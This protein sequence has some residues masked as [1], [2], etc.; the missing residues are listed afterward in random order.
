MKVHTLIVAHSVLATFETHEDA[1]LAADVI[2]ALIGIRPRVVIDHKDPD[3][4]FITKAMASR[5]LL[6]LIDHLAV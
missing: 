1:D 6:A 4:L 2:C 3:C 5:N